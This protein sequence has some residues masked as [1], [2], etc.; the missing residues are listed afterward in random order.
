LAQSLATLRQAQ[1]LKIEM[2]IELPEEVKQRNNLKKWSVYGSIFLVLVFALLAFRLLLKPTVQRSRI[3]TAK[4]EKGSIEAT[5]SASGIVVARFEQSISTPIEARIEKV[6]HQSGEQVNAGESI[7]L[8]NREFSMLAL[9]KLKDEQSLKKNKIVQLKLSLQKTVNELESQYQ[10]QK[11]KVE[12]LGSL[13]DDEKQLKKIG[14]TT[15]D[16][17]KQAELNLKISSQELELLEKKI[18]NQKESVVA[19]LRA[20]DL[21]I[22]I[23]QKTISELERKIQQ[24][25][26]RAEQ[27]GVITWVNENIGSTVRSGELLAKIADLSSYKIEATISDNFGAQLQVGGAVIVK[28]DE[29]ELRGTIS[30][31]NPSVINGSLNFNVELDDK[32]N[33]VLRPKL[34]ADVYVIT[35]FQANVLRVKNGPFYNGS[36]NQKVFVLDGDKAIATSVQLGESN[37]DFVQVSG[38]NEGDEIIISSMS[39]FER[40]EAV[41]IKND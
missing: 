34:R 35:S 4:V 25:E 31:I 41:E 16:K 20:Q 9:E 3:L 10:I 28:I 2:D 21:E 36:N 37:F 13:Y 11:L 14:G 40:T 26:V 39:D 17:L 29:N 23:Q 24:A 32:A 8:L 1:E 22:S 38:L 12:S 30:N 18:Q 27:K 19:D 6:L 15:D 7:L 33:K 5:V